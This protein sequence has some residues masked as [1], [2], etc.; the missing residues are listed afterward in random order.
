VEQLASLRAFFPNLSVPIRVM[1]GAQRQ[2]VAVAWAAAFAGTLVIAQEPTA[3]LG[4]QKTVQGEN[5]IRGLKVCGV[6]L[7]LIS[8]GL[9]Q[10]FDLVDRIV[11]IRRGPGTAWHCCAAT[12][13]TAMI[14]SATSPGVKGG[15]GATA[16]QGGS[17]P[18]TGASVE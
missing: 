15:E 10:M 13:R 3:V 2:C 6:P 14:V 17:R 11:V 8:R 9:R 7:I 1:P 12:K 5:T 16:C 18:D 4:V